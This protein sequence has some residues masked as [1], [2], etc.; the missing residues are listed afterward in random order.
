MRIDYDIS[1][2]IL[3][4][5]CGRNNNKKEAALFATSIAKLNVGVAVA[6][7]SRVGVAGVLP[8]RGDRTTVVPTSVAWFSE[9]RIARLAGV[10]RASW[11]M[12]ERRGY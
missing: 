11:P 3:S 7:P 1:N 5:A 2:S 9:I 4:V 8:P 10:A 12:R 6:L